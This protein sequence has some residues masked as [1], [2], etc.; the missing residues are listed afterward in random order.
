MARVIDSKIPNLDTSWENYTGERVEEFIKQNFKD[1]DALKFGYLTIEKGVGGLQTMRFF[2]SQE[3]YSKWF[4]DKARYADN[5]LKEYSF[6]S[7]APEPSWNTRAQI[8]KYPL[9]NISRGSKNVLALA[10]NCFYGDDES[11]KDTS[12]GLLTV[13][14]NGVK[15]SSLQRTLV[16][17]GT[18]V[19]NVY[20]ID[21]S[22][23]L[24]SEH[25]T[26]I[27]TV[28]NTH[29][30]TKTFKFEIVVYNLT[31]SFDNNY[32]E[33]KVQNGKWDLRV[34]CN[35]AEAIV[36][37]QVENDGKKDVYTK[38]INNSSGEFTIDPNQ[39]YV[40][41]AHEITLWAENK[42]LGIKTSELKTTY[43]KGADT[44]NVVSALCF[45]KGI[46]NSAKQFSIVEVPYYFYLPNDE[47]GSKIK[48]ETKVLFN[49]NAKSVKLSDQVVTLSSTHESGLKKV[50]VALDNGNYLPFI[51]I[52]IKVGDL[53]IERKIEVTSIGVSIKDVDEC[54]VLYSMKGKTNSDAD[55]QNLTSSYA[56]VITSRLLR[57]KNFLFDENNGFLDGYGITV[58]P[59]KTLTLNDFQ[60]FSTDIGA[61]GTKQGRTIEIE[62]QSGITSDENSI[63]IDC[64]NNGTGF[65]IFANRIQF[66][67][68]TGSVITYFPEQTRVKASF[69]VDGTTTHTRNDLGGGNIQ[70]SDVNLAYLYVNGV[71][72]RLFDYSTA[73]WRQG[74]AKNIVIGSDSALVE[75][76]SLRIYDKALNYSQ[77]VDNYAYDTPDVEDVFDSSGNLVRFGKVSI[78]RRNN[79]LNSS[80]D[81]HQ[82]SEIVSYDKVLKALPNTPTIIWNIDDL[83]Y[84]KNNPNV[85]INGTKF[86]N[87]LWTKEGWGLACAPFTVGAHMFNAD[88]T[89]SNGYPLPYKNWAEVFKTADGNSVNITIDPENSN[90][91]V[92][93]YSITKGLSNGET[94]MVHKVNFASS[95][96]IFNIHAMNLFHEL[97]LKLGKTNNELY[98]KFQLSQIGGDVVYRKSL[99]GFP[100]IGFR[101]TSASGSE[102]PKFLS[103]YNFINNKYSASIFGFPTKSYKTAQIWEID[104]NVNFF[105]RLLTDN[106]IS[107]GKVVQSNATKKSGPIYY[108]R[109]PK[110]SPTN[111]DNKFGQLKA[112]TDNVKASNDELACIKR[113]HNWVVSCNYHLAERYKK[114]HGDYE[115]LSTPVTY[116][117][118]KYTQDSVEYRK[119]K[120][121]NTY[122]DY[123]NKDDAMFYVI[124]CVFII[125]MD[126]LDK[127]M[128]L[129][130]D[131][132]VTADNGDV[133]KAIARLFLR[134]TDTRDLF[135][136]SGVLT[137]KY[138]AEW[139]DAF[140]SSTLKTEQISGEEYDSDSNAWSPKVSSGFSP[141][142][143]G[144]LS[145]LIDLI[146][147]C[148]EDDI[149]AM[150]K[151]MRDAGLNSTYMYNLYLSYWRQWC[152]NLYNVDSMGYVNT[153]N[154]T[155]A[156]GDKLQL[157]RYFYEK[158]SRYLDS[159][160]CCGA[161]VVNNLR[162]RLYDQGKGL[163]I[164]HYSPMYASVQWGANNFATVRNIDGGYG[165]IPFGFK[166]PQ[167]A[168][169][170]IDDADMITDIKTYTRSASG[171]VKYYGL[172]GLGNFYFDQN[173]SLCTRLEEFILDYPENSPNTQI[174]GTSNEFDLSKMTLLK[175]VIVRNVKN[176]K[177]LVEINSEVVS[178][179][180]FKNTSIKGIK[181]LPNQYLRKLV[182]PESIEELYLTGFTNLQSGDLEL[183]GIGNVNK[184]VYYDCPNI[185]FATML[186]KL[187][188]NGKLKFIEAKNID[189]TITDKSVWDILINSNADLQ[190]K[191][192][193]SGF[194]LSFEDK[195]KAVE[196]WGNID[197]NSNK[198]HIV[199]NIINCTA[200]E[201]SGDS[202]I[203]EVAD[204]EYS[205]YA[206]PISANNISS[207]SWSITENP[208]AT[209]NPKTGQLYVTKISSTKDDTSAKATIKA[210]VVKSDG[211]VLKAEFNVGFYKR[212]VKVGDYLLN[213][214]TFSDVT[215]NLG[216]YVVAKVIY[217]D[218]DNLYC[219]AVNTN[220]EIETSACFPI[221]MEQKQYNIESLVQLDKYAIITDIENPNGVFEELR[222]NFGKYKSGMILPRALVNTIKCIAL[223]NDICSYLNLEVPSADD[224]AVDTVDVVKRINSISSKQSLYMK[225]IRKAWEWC[226]RV[227]N[228][229]PKLGAHNWFIADYKLYLY[230]FKNTPKDSR[231]IFQEQWYITCDYRYNNNNNNNNTIGS[232]IGIYKYYYD[233]PRN[234]FRYYV[235]LS[236][237]SNSRILGTNQLFIIL[238][239]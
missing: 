179:I 61:N 81:V 216:K 40:L 173:M 146:W 160:F 223:S 155:K 238:K 62:F 87:P 164:K 30:F 41:G 231:N 44:G 140:N 72:V 6:Y 27:V 192:T 208:Y 213:D 26:V 105:N 228:L 116:N 126:S 234:T 47:T 53:T 64:W 232:S 69:V 60:P 80:G 52:Q 14:I 34:N 23:Y 12:N 46:V 96:G 57:S 91:V 209:I 161:S 125:G 182:L 226:P 94:D 98:T 198:L 158:R 15:I 206:T 28:T 221:A 84:N 113:F 43:I 103:I 194:T 112:I 149:K 195:V 36:Y 4:S 32:D 131:D 118:T 35:G 199:Y 68:S 122:R 33:S 217:I 168:T 10:Y 83:P 111:K 100:E 207:V 211:S 19:S 1:V 172:E 214:A 170:D 190:G 222:F 86:S 137:Y 203:Q 79:I 201:I 39:K 184:F 92:T 204:S 202:Y 175:K 188:A 123:L 225:Q 21:L 133:T 117:G 169:F 186:V 16:A 66:G 76:Y 29:G 5:L 70:E 219:M 31:I 178:E 115:T 11:D 181:T 114:Q 171:E 58:R 215:N 218:N 56:G 135:N 134:D 130:F 8:S 38:T 104:E 148:W 49:N 90:E 141:V 127:N 196:K 9:N 97:V 108:A 106:E 74:D 65:R 237:G 99:S 165:L 147:N 129:A 128:S 7:N 236:Q 193:L 210:E 109:V 156:Y 110:K 25:N 153:G 42:E 162:L 185:D 142:F 138:W 136:N 48:V 183:A 121:I 224:D 166:N 176:L 59:G 55:A 102:S 119:A 157:S 67:C 45:G 187:A 73:N 77:I 13:D 205:I 51:T 95:E 54:K 220:N 124:F 82:P 159:K 163:A 227:P 3:A 107:N 63:I 24:T 191:I 89:S 37:C 180:N 143:N 85:P 174:D 144:R 151:T 78:A 197:D 18:P 154:F 229:S 101:R 235:E 212:T 230:L 22:E 17:S 239:K 71:I 75:L 2:A 167:N 20:E 120:F 152:E 139:N 88:G 50:I 93:A 189:L 233:E 132:I 177:K 145:G 200:V 150:Y